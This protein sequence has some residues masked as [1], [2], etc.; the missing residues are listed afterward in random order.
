MDLSKLVEIGERQA[1]TCADLQAL[2]Q[3]EQEAARAE[4]RLAREQAK[5]EEEAARAEHGLAREQA[6]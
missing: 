2:V 5:E 6:K 4:R 1:I 3:D